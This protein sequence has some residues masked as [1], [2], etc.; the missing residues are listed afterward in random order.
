[1]EKLASV[2][3]RKAREPSRGRVP[4]LR[5]TARSQITKMTCTHIYIILA[6]AHMCSFFVF[7]VL[8]LHSCGPFVFS[9]PTKNTKRV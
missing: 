5:R 2:L 7:C 6:M 3:Y 1:M 9:N 8:L 4:A